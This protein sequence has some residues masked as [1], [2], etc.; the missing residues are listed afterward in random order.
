MVVRLTGP[1]R[2]IY[3]LFQNYKNV[4]LFITIADLSL[5]ILTKKSI[6]TGSGT[7]QFLKKL[8]IFKQILE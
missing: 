4:K 1:E 5:M 6:L 3:T 8:N 7:E 2:E